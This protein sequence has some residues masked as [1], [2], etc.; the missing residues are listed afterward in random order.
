MQT[1]G[2]T[3]EVVTSVITAIADP[4]V[5]P[6]IVKR[7][8]LTPDVAIWVQRAYDIAAGKS[9][10]LARRQDEFDASSALSSACTCLDIFPGTVTVTATASTSVRINIKVMFNEHG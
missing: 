2:T 1:S 10:R 8:R 5:D 7:D 3:T 4:L 6:V 9:P